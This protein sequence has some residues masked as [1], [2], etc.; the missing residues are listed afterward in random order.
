PSKRDLNNE[1]MAMNG[2][3]QADIELLK[4]ME[5]ENKGEYV[6]ALSLNKDGSI[7][8]TATSFI[9]HEEFS[10]IFDHIEK[11]MQK[12]GDSIAKGEINIDPV[13]GREST[14]CVYCDF[15]SVCN[16]ESDFAFKVPNLKNSEVFQQ[17]AKEDNNGL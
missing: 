8:K 11:L 15:K 7:A 9:S 10:L 4:A 6:P 1:G 17:I 14:A 16:F 2:L 5:E 12:T 3:I 13:D